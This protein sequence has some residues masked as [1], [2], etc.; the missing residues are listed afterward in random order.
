MGSIAEHSRIEQADEIKVHAERV[1]EGVQ[2]RAPHFGVGDVP[3]RMIAT[4]W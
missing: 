2:G 1:P 3:D 4:G